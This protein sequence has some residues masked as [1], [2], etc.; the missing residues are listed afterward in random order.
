MDLFG[1]SGGFSWQDAVLT[2][3]T[4]VFLAALVP[5]IIGERKPAPL[6]SLLTGGVLFIFAATYAT[7]G[8]YFAGITTAATGTAW[9]IILWQTLRRGINRIGDRHG[10]D[11]EG[12]GS[13]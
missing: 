7:L 8:L 10:C 4:L 12:S 2:S 13:L 6:T 1:F 9:G 3:G 11:P 5:T